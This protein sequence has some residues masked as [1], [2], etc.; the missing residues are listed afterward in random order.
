MEK[1]KI[2]NLTES[3]EIF[4]DT[5][6]DMNKV[7]HNQTNN[8]T[9]FKFEI[10]NNYIKPNL[11][12]YNNETRKWINFE[13]LNRYQIEYLKE[14]KDIQELEKIMDNSIENSNSTIFGVFEEIYTFFKNSFN[15]ITLST[16]GLVIIPLSLSL[17]VYCIRKG[18]S[19]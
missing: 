12:R 18:L 9:N 1:E 4:F 19:N 5:F 8:Q 17:L 15:N 16:T 2:L 11:T 13:K 14:Y 6:C 10:T 3:T 7:T